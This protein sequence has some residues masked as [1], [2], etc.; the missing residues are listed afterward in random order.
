MSP[1]T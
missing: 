1:D